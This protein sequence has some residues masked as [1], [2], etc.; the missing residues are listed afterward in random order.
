VSAYPVVLEGAS[1]EALIVGGG[2]VAERKARAL[3]DAEA[4]VRVVAPM[5]A[6]ALH[7][8]AAQVSPRLSL[9]E[10]P[11]AP[12]DIGRAT[13]VVAATNDR[14]VNA[15]VAA[16]A[17]RAGR[18]VNVADDPAAGNCMTVAAHRSGPLV[19]GVTAGVPTAAAYIRDAIAERFDGRYADALSALAALRARL[20]AAG[21]R[22]AWRRAVDTFVGDD[23]CA[24][25][26]AADGRFAEE[27]SAWH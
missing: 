4:R 24:R 5:I 6:P 27:V 13:L 26:E 8:L 7:E 15:L 21:D 11:Y 2:A 12:T 14:E 17:R 23:F 9:L 16:D 25:V 10:R 19:I 20:L 3:L 1:I 18:L 22:D